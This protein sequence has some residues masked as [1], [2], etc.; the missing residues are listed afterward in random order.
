M[1]YENRMVIKHHYGTN[2][3]TSLLK[4]KNEF[5]MSFTVQSKAKQL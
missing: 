4:F 1:I 5:E 3:T 2:N